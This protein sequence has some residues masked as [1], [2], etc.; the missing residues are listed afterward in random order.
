MEKIQSE[1][2]QQKCIKIQYPLIAAQL[3][4]LI[5]HM[6]NFP[7]PLEKQNSLLRTLA[8]ILERRIG[9]FFMEDEVERDKKRQRS[10]TCNF[11]GW[12]LKHEKY[13][14]R[15]WRRKLKDPNK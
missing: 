8:C 4:N 6:G 5:T 13:K 2:E 3:Y 12:I 14:S 7:A 15:E 11:L 9:F 10:K 1:N